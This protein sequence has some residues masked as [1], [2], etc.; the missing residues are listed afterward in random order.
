M[1]DLATIFT[2]QPLSSED[3][4]LVDAYERVGVSLDKLPYTEHFDRIVRMLGYSDA[5][6]QDRKYM[7]H[8]R[9][10]R[11]RKAGRLPRVGRYG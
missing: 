6:T 5:D 2:S 1:S 4:Q 7:V 8:Q 9:L 11:L 3:E 10:L